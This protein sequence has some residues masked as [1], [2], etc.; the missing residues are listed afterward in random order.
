MLESHSILAEGISLALSRWNA[1]Q[2]AIQNEW[3]GRD[4]LEKSE[5]LADDLF[6]WFSQPKVS[7]CIDDLEH[8]LDEAMMLSF[9]TDIE[10][11]SIEEVAEELMLMHEDCLHGNYD[12]IEKLRTSNSKTRAISLS[13]KVNLLHP[14]P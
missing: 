10:D 3:G 11:G 7:L 1:L 9:H 4:S 8:V 13:T 12:S 2:M 14:T 6:S 5:K